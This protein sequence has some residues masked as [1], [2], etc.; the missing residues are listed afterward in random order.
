[1]TFVRAKLMI[2]AMES[3]AIGEIRLTGAEPLSN[4]PR[5]ITEYGHEILE[6]SPEP[7]QDTAGVHRL[8]IRKR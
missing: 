5:A 4:V 1:M 3:G 6:L 8:R 7:G 2:E